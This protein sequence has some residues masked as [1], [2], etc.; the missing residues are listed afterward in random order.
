MARMRNCRQILV[1]PMAR[2][3]NCR[4]SWLPLAS[5]GLSWRFLALPGVV[6][7]PGV[8]WRLLASPGVPWPLCQH[9][10]PS[11]LI[12]GSPGLSWRLL[13]SLGLP[14][15]SWPLLA[16]FAKPARDASGRVAGR[17]ASAV[18]I[19]GKRHLA[20]LALNAIWA[21]GRSQS[22]RHTHVGKW[23]L[24][25]LAPD[26]Q[27]AARKPSPGTFPVNAEPDCWRHSQIQRSHHGTCATLGQHAWSHPG[28]GNLGAFGG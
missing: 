8:P 18:C 26:A 12:L 4:P 27:L 14:W 9:V 15:F 22:R 17:K 2:M 19:L 7:S 3:R 16:Q 23:Q 11:L 28:G 10:A 20:K 1:S 5:P 25:K 6:A 21:G 24:A 13:P